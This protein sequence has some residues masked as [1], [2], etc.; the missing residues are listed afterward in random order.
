[1]MAPRASWVCI[2]AVLLAAGCRGGGVTPRTATDANACGERR[3]SPGGRPCCTPGGTMG[4]VPGTTC[5]SC[6]APTC[7]GCPEDRPGVTCIPAQNDGGVY[8]R[9]V[10]D[11]EE[12]E[13]KVIGA[14]C[15]N[16][17]GTSSR[18]TTIPAQV[19]AAV[20]NPGADARG[21]VQ[22]APV[23]VQIC[24]RCG[25]S[26]CAPWENSC[27]CPADCAPADSPTR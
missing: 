21:C 1:M 8:G 10:A 17:A 6:V 13:G 2:G 23:S 15:C 20:G 11:G 18:G 4:E 22:R 7:R 26:V 24:A 27:N 19:P 12:I 9:C 16:R 3:I 25:D 14:Y 5:D